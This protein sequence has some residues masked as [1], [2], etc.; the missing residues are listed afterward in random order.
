MKIYRPCKTNLISQKF[1]EN[2]NPYYKE[3]GMLGHEGYDFSV[4]CKNNKAKTGGQCEN[5]YCNIEGDGQMTIIYIQKDVGMGFGLMAIDENWNK[6]LWW[7]FDSINPA[8]VVGS[9]IN[10]GDLLGIAGNTGVSTGAHCHFQYNPYGANPNN[11]YEGAVDII[12]WFDNRFI[13]DIEKQIGIIKQTILL[14][15]QVINILFPKK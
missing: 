3:H 6:F 1:G 13:L 7:H 4:S 15:Q 8:L 10:P 12:Q 2:L 9:K 14:I 11:G 5:V